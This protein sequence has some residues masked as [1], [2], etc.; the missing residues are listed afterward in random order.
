MKC[1]TCNIDLEKRILIE[2]EKI[3]I[4]QT[5]LT[6]VEIGETPEEYG[7]SGF[8]DIYET[9]KVERRYLI[10]SM[11]GYKEQLEKAENETQNTEN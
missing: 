8:G 7:H 2:D 11:C 4:A 10:C 5:N 1:P 3:L 9:R 6:G